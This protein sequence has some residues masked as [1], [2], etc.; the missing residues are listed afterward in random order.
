M[1][2]EKELI[3]KDQYRTNELS[4]KPGG[5]NVKVIHE[6]GRSFVYDKIKS[7]ASYVAYISR[8]ENANGNITEIQI[9]GKTIWK[10]GNN[11]SDWNIR[12]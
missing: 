1:A 5:F 10:E 9:E 12:I 4:L 8:T 7:P 6:N 11:L 2:N 3:V